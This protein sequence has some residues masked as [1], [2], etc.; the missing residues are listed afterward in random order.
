[1]PLAGS[2]NIAGTPSAAASRKKAQRVLQQEVPLPHQLAPR[3][4]ELRRAWQQALLQAERRPASSA[5]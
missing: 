1:M 4:G 2:S 3:E 5:P